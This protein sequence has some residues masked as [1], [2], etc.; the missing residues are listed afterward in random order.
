MLRVLSDGVAVRCATAQSVW[1]RSAAIQAQSDNCSQLRVGRTSLNRSVLIRSRSA[2]ARLLGSKE[3]PRGSAVEYKQF[4]V[5]VFEQQPGK[6]RARVKRL[7][8]KP[9]MVARR[10][11]ARIDEFVTSP[12]SATPNGALLKAFAAIDAGAFSRPGVA[13]GKGGTPSAGYRLRAP[14]ARK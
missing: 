8:G 3:A 9:L 13:V 6:W 7:D 11:K 12:D 5:K 2:N 1:S 4:I 14:G 10:G